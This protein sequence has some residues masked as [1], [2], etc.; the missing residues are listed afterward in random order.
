MGSCNELPIQD[1][2]GAPGPR[3]FST[4]N[5]GS[6]PTS[7]VPTP[8]S[9]GSSINPDR[10]HLHPT[11]RGLMWSTACCKF[12]PS[13][14]FWFH[15]RIRQCPADCTTQWSQ[16]IGHGAVFLQL[17]QSYL[18]EWSGDYTDHPPFVKY[19]MIRYSKF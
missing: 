11:C 2:S 4:G 12:V 13:I 3:S 16:R 18:L 1:G 9:A 6:T 8:L 15:C 19:P 7:G 5:P 17:F 10:Q 14:E